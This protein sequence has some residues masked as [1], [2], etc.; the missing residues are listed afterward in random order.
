MDSYNLV[1]CE[2]DEDARILLGMLVYFLFLATLLFFTFVFCV[3]TNMPNF[4]EK[5]VNVAKKT[6]RFD[7][8][9]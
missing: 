1:K 9:S 7:L 5:L 6:T 4:Q 2:N 8:E 3:A